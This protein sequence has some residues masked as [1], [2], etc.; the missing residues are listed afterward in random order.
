MQKRRIRKRDKREGEATREHI[1]AKTAAL[2]N[3]SGYLRTPLSKI[4]RVT[5][6]QKGGLYHH[7]G[8]RDDLALA[9]FQ[10]NVG[11]VQARV[12][13]VLKTNTS[14]TDKLLSLI[15]VFR[16]FPRE[17]V[18]EGGCPIVNLAIEA[19]D[20]HRA[21][22][23]AARK[24]MAQLISAFERVIVA[25]MKDGQFPKGNARQN[26]AMFVSSLEGALLLTVLYKDN[27]YLQ[28]VVDHLR[29]QVKTGLR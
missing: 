18:L 22:A 23:A 3:K 21:L 28:G 26:A 29:G 2:L 11:L 13:Q 9:A 10:H 4:M 7:F 19:D 25:G 15:N 20:A 27:S 14:S 1:I 16:D 8:S 17:D 12:K 5:A 6:L 24:A